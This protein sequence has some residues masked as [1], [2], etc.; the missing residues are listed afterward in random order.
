MYRISIKDFSTICEK[1]YP[2]SSKSLTEASE[3]LLLN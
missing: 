1:Y 2:E 3:Y